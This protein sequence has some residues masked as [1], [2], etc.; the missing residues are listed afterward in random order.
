M[1][2]RREQTEELFKRQNEQNIVVGDGVVGR[3]PGFS[4][5]CAD[6]VVLNRKRNRLAGRLLGHSNLIIHG[7]EF[8]YWPE[9]FPQ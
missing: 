9:P 8:S 1:I 7:A 3:V 5:D 6:R 4:L 2:E